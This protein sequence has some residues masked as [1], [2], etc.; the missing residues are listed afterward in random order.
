MKIRSVAIAVFVSLMRFL[1]SVLMGAFVAR[2]VQQVLGLS[3]TV[4]G[5]LHDPAGAGAGRRRADRGRMLDKAGPRQ[6]R[7]ARRG[8]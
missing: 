5:L 2:Y 1:P 4:A 3:P 8:A 6:A 7:V